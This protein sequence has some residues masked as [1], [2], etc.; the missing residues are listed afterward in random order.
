MAE[1]PSGVCVIPVSKVDRVRVIVILAAVLASA[2][3][4][5]EEP[6]AAPV[7]AEGAE[8]SSEA[9]PPPVD[10]PAAELPPAAE[11]PPTAP[12]AEELAATEPAPT[13][14]APME[15][16]VPEPAAPVAPMAPVAPVVSAPPAAGTTAPPTTEAEVG[17]AAATP[18]ASG[19][20]AQSAAA[21]ALLG[22]PEGW[23]ISGSWAL[24]LGAQTDAHLANASSQLQVGANYKLHP[25]VF[26]AGS[27]TPSLNLDPLPDSGR[28]FELSTL[29]TFARLN[30]RNLYHEEI[31]GLRLGGNVSYFLPVNWDNF[32]GN[33]PTLG[34]LGSAVQLFR[35]F[36]PV[37]LIGSLGL[38]LP[39]F[40]RGGAQ[41]QCDEANPGLASGCPQ[42]ATGAVNPL[43][44]VS[45]GV[46]AIASFDRVTLIGALSVLHTWTRFLSFADDPRRGDG[47]FANIERNSFAFF[48]QAGYAID[49][50]LTLNLGIFNGGPQV[51][52]LEFNNPF[53]DPK[54]AAF[55][56]GVDWV[57]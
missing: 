17:A 48:G 40:L 31:T 56:V 2:V 29:G 37:N 11:A 24:Y 3:V 49:D 20:S 18:P 22:P 52:G 53:F 33:N 12:V 44:S 27:I 46:T 43:L 6:G 41:H 39:L 4:H 5:G 21:A 7:A 36:G 57:R 14:P 38:N 13:E 34:G 55:F 9:P 23:Q 50:H 16:A 32:Y 30:F 25:K 45:A 19:E 8:A 26:F 1:T 47:A 15:P 54:F 42:A 28:R 10:E 35:N 51:T